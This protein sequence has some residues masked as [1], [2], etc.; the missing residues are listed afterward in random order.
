MKI[1]GRCH[2]GA[3]TYEAEVDPEHTSICHCTDCQQLVGHRVP[4]LD[5]RRHDQFKILTGE[6]KVYVKIGDSGGQARA[7][8]LRELR[9][10]DLRHRGR[11]QCALQ[12][13]RRHGAA[14][15]SAGAEGA[16][17]DP[18]RA[19]MA[20]RPGRDP[21]GREAGLAHPFS[22]MTGAR[23]LGDNPGNRAFREEFECAV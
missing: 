9:L 21:Q 10:A 5:P 16:D 3:I 13:P 2:C 15:R 6:P 12:H 8:V 20:S 7:G 23:E 17:L 14:A 18:F 11:G 1:D 4:D 19:A 22:P